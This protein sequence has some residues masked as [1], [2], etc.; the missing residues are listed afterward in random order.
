MAAEVV[1][2]EVTISAAAA[3]FNVIRAFKSRGS[4]KEGKKTEQTLLLSLPSYFP[5]EFHKR[6]GKENRSSCCR[7]Q[8]SH[9]G[10]S[11]E[12]N[13]SL[14][15]DKQNGDYGS[16]KEECCN[17][18]ALLCFINGSLRRGV[19]TPRRHKK[20]RWCLPKV[21]SSGHA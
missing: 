1:V 20:R 4:G 19:E 15:S 17:V 6:Q 2:V 5:I 11:G 21:F 3:A 16:S 18:G 7:W 13:F 14:R 12:E 10:K 8:K 9:K